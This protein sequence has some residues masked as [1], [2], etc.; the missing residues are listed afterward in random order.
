MYWSLNWCKDHN[1]H[2]FVVLHLSSTYLTV[3][4]SV[5]WYHVLSS[6]AHMPAIHVCDNNKK[7]EKCNVKSSLIKYD[8]Q[9]CTKQ[10]FVNVSV[11]CLLFCVYLF[12]VTVLPETD[13]CCYCINIVMQLL[14]LLPSW[15]TLTQVQHTTQLK[16]DWFQ[17]VSVFISHFLD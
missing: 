11:A 2:Y 10:K 1:L 12:P 6:C 9:I 16:N 8:D 15:H 5:C 17:N 13:T 4:T 14:P 3:S 7:E